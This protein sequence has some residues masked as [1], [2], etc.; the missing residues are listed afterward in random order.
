MVSRQT[1]C[2]DARIIEALS[3]G[4]SW[5]PG[6]SRAPG[7]LSVRGNRTPSSAEGRQYEPARATYWPRE[8]R[9]THWKSVLTAE[10]VGPNVAADSRTAS[11]LRGEDWSS[12][13]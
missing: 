1:S 6:C 8:R 10:R 11:I 9:R 5:N 4:T 12:L 7:R 3:A 2:N 13:L